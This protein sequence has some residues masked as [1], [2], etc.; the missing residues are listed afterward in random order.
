MK[1]L[2]ANR[3]TLQTGD[4]VSF[5]VTLASPLL[6]AVALTIDLS[7]IIALSSFCQFILGW[8]AIISMDVARASFVIVYFVISFGYFILF[9]WAQDG[10]TFGKR[11]MHVRV[12]DIQMRSLSLSQ[13]V[14]RNIFRVLDMFP[15]FYL[16]GGMVAMLSPKNQ[17]LGDI[18]A[19]TIVVRDRKQQPPAIGEL[20]DNKYNSLR[21]HP[22]QELLL[23]KNTS[24]AEAAM[25][26]EA[27]LRRDNLEAGHRVTLFKEL[28]KLFRSKARFPGEIMEGCSDEQ[29]IRNCID[30]LY[31]QKREL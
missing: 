11:Y 28:A 31:R 29:F 14:L 4:A 8:F 23:R 18:A 10:R 22:N 25:A 5:S 13:V 1:T 2:S 27:L 19:A 20:N 24:P 21:K 16:T 6:R 12:M 15:F 3:L 7:L 30:S 17:R 26:L 9:E